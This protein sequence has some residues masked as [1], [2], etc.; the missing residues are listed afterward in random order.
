MLRWM[1]VLCFGLFQQDTHDPFVSPSNSMAGGVYI[2]V[3]VTHSS[4]FD[5]CCSYGESQDLSTHRVMTAFVVCA[6]VPEL[7][8][9]GIIRSLLL[10]YCVSLL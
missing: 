2:S 9:Q 7:V 1:T 5:T 3:S 4:I 10:N 8:V 6:E